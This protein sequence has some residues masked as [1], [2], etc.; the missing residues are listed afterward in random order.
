ML[1]EFVQTL[2]S[3]YAAHKIKCL[4]VGIEIA[5]DVHPNSLSPIMCAPSLWNLLCI[6]TVTLFCAHGDWRCLLT[7]R[8]LEL[9]E[10][11]MRA[12]ASS[13]APPLLDLYV[14]L[15]FNQGAHT[16]AFVWAALDRIVAVLSEVSPTTVL[17]LGSRSAN[18]FYVDLSSFTTTGAVRIEYED[19]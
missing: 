12:R 9:F 16:A 13:G 1:G 19:V 14:A 5:S 11:C 4:Q 10:Q 17:R 8:H 15:I 18:D 6:P 7:R 2:T 3:P